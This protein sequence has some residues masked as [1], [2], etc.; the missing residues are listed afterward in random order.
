MVNLKKEKTTMKLAIGIDVHKGKCTACAAYA[1]TGEPRERHLDF[2]EKFNKDFERFHSDGRGML[3]LHNYLKGHE[4]HILIEN[5]TISHSIYWM[6]KELGHDTIVAHSTDLVRITK[7]DRKNDVNDA[8]EL[9]HYMRRKL[10]GESEFHESYI[11][12]KD[13]LMQREIC[14]F[15]FL[16]RSDLTDTKRRIRS[17]LLVRGEPLSMN[18]DDVMRKDAIK[19][20][21]ALNDKAIT[22]HVHK[23]IALKERIVF[24]DKV[25]RSMFMDDPV[26]D[27][28]YSVPGFGVLSAAYV[29]CMG[30]D[31]TRFA[32][33]RGYSASIGLIPKQRESNDKGSNCGITRRGDPD[34]RRIFTQAA[35]VHVRYADSFI[36]RKYERLRDS[37][38]S[39]NETIVACANSLARLIHKM[40][41]SNTKYVSD[42]KELARSREYVRNGDIE[43]DMDNADS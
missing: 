27:I 35:F 11:P 5:S 2:I 19:E 13:V 21:L 4:S 17:L 23:A 31:F 6:L 25:L 15:S 26:F 29:R 7:S 38:K 34:L 33:G 41:M 9:A 10:I 20:M 28:I 14:R 39:H 12:P 1:G 30:D 32:D 42:P 22:L 3:A 43:D 16:D 24:V 37:G 8:Y 40:V 18:Y 36:A